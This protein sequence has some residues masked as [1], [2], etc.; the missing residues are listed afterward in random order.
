ML[1]KEDNELIT[2][3]NPGAPMGDLFRRFWLPVAL[4][5]E[6]PGPDCVP[7]RVQVLNEKLVAF[8]DS[9]GRVGVLDAYCPHRGAPLFFGRNEESGLR[10][11]YHGWKFDVDGVCTDIPNAPEGETFKAKIKIKRYPCVEAGDLIWAY[12]GPADKQPPFPEFEWTKLPKTNRYVTKFVMECNYLQAM[13]GD[14][15]PGHG[16]FLHTKIDGSPQVPQFNTQVRPRIRPVPENEPFPRAVGPRRQTERD[17]A[18]W[19]HIEDTESGMFF[20]QSGERPDGTK[21]A[22]V[23]PW[24]MPIY[25]TA[26]TTAGTNTMSTNIRVPIDNERIFFYR[27]RWSYNALPDAEVEEYKHGGWYYPELIPG[28]YIPK[29]NVHNDYLI[30]RQVQRNF[31]YS[32]IACFPLQDISMMEDQWG[33][34]ADRTLEHLTSSDFQIIYVRRRLLKTVK[35]LMQGV[36]PGEPWHPKAY[37]FHR[38]S[39]VTQEGTLEQAVAKAKELA[40]AQK[41]EAPMIPVS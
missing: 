34:L 8:R 39:V 28:S 6:L 35:A 2:N 41:I 26:G 4:A 15:D 33:P 13:E 22:T 38:A 3:I 5:E 29:A 20:I 16:P 11:I 23:A 30:D 31:T 32:G 24:M 1:S 37:A 36:E 27:L 17:K 25:C 21:V 10:C 18:A 40:R 19:G 7:L 14:Y 12:M 9:D